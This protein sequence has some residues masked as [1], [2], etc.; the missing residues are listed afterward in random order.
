MKQGHMVS[1]IYLLSFAILNRF[2]E[3]ILFHDF[4]VQEF[5]DCIN[6]HLPSGLKFLSIEYR[7]DDVVSTILHQL[8]SEM[9][10][11][12]IYDE[13]A[14]FE[15]EMGYLH[16][17][18]EGHDDVSRQRNEEI[19]FVIS[20]L[21]ESYYYV[22]SYFYYLGEGKVC[23]FVKIHTYNSN[24]D[25]DEFVHSNLDCFAPLLESYFYRGEIPDSYADKIAKYLLLFG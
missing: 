20:K 19:E 17:R 3:D 4:L 2:Q 13:V 16:I 23:R 12:N 11:A 22:A 24:V 18:L 1:D 21:H 15:I 5:P 25:S 6:D 7:I 14:D 9:S 8:I 10:D